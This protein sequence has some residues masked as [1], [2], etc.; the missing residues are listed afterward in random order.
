[1]SP[2]EM[3]YDFDLKI[4]RVASLSKEDF[5][6]AERDWLLNEAQWVFLKQRY[7]INNIKR[8]GFEG[9]QKRIDD[10]SFL[11]IK[12]PLQPTVPLISHS[13]VYELDL[14]DLK[15]DYLF[16]TRAWVNYE[17]TTCG[18]T[19]SMTIKETEN[20]DLNRALDDPFND[21]SSEFIPGNFGRSSSDSDSSSI[22]LYTPLEITE[23]YVEYLRIPPKINLGGYTYIDGVTY[24]TQSSIFPQHT[25][26]EI[27]DIAVN[28]AA[29]IIENPQ[30][31]Q[32][33]ER[34]VLTHE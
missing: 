22:Y 2:R 4:D 18:T 13:G 1:M 33:K 3:H 32:L 27:V 9:S 26:P 25:H 8:T 19:T 10:L 5:N 28:I 24:P 34:K 14:S 20:D 6:S 23:A 17:D 7:G 12:Y 15:Y 29:G 31:V 16:L 11:H 30:Y 21:G